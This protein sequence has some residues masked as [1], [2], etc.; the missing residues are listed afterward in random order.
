MGDKA[1]SYVAAAL[2]TNQTLKRLDLTSNSIGRCEVCCMPWCLLICSHA[3][4]FATSIYN[5][6]FSVAEGHALTGCWCDAERH[7]GTQ[8]AYTLT[9][10]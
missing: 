2:H 10:L 5:L 4:V 8:R 9:F 1:F 3:L 7:H 6:S